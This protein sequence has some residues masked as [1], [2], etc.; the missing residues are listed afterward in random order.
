M[1]AE[2]IPAKLK[3]V[4]LRIFSRESIAFLTTLMACAAFLVGAVR[5]WG[6]SADRLL[7]GLALILFM[8][9]GLALLALITVVVIKLL[10]RKR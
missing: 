10:R 2:G 3:R 8:L 1:P 9:G 4:L 6:V 5:I 7:S